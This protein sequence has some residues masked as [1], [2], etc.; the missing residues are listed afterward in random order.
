MIFYSKKLL[1]IYFSSLFLS[2]L[3]TGTTQAQNKK[4]N[5]SVTQ[6]F[7]NLTTDLERGNYYYKRLNYKEAFPFYKKLALK[8]NP[9][10]QFYLGKMHLIGQ[11]VARDY[12]KAFAWFKKAALQGHSI[13]QYNLAIMYDNG[14]GVDKDH[15]KAIFWYEKAARQ[16]NIQAQYDLGWMYYKAK[17]YKK[18][19]FWYKQLAE[20]G[21]AQAQFNL[22]IMYWHLKDYK[23]T[24][25]WATLA[26]NQGHS[27]A[28]KKLAE[29]Y[30]YGDGITQ[31]H[32][33]A[34]PLLRQL[35]KQGDTEAQYNLS[36]ILYKEKLIRIGNRIIGLNPNEQ[37]QKPSQKNIKAQRAIPF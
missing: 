25:H 5:R 31:D 4:S 23:K 37:N 18:S 11:E 24:V 10:A 8:G 36:V 28:K 30:L 12:N 3:L 27:Q 6:N 34:I 7:N 1:K 14:E 9:Q 26:S 15:P 22:A 13:A 17:D 16:K 35:A 29:M 19:A 2:L 21:H 32:P 20:Q 33:K